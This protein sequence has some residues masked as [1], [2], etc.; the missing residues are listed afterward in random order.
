MSD[1]DFRF[2]DDDL[3]GDDDDLFGDDDD[4]FGGDDDFGSGF[5]DF[6][7]DADLDADLDIP[8]VGPDFTD[9][10]TVVVEEEGGSNRMFVIIA[11]IMLLLLI[12]GFA[13]IAFLALRGTV[14][15]E[16]DAT[17]TAIVAQNMTIEAF[18]TQTEIANTEIAAVTLTAAAASPTPT[19]TP[20]PTIDVPATETQ[21]AV[22][23]G[24]TQTFEA[25]QLTLT[26]SESVMDSLTE[27]AAAVSAE[28]AAATQTALA[29]GPSSVEQTATA[30]A[31]A[32]VP[33]MVEAPNLSEV[34]MTATALA[35]LFATPVVTPG[36]AIPTQE[37]IPT[38]TGGTPS[39]QLP[40]TGIFDDLAAG[41]PGT[42]LLAAF[43]LL[44]V[45]FVSR[46]VRKN[47]SA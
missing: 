24:I 16:R 9:V 7:N 37:I 29:V 34:Q 36:D 46:A 35:T 43:G 1:D 18:Q 25:D 31:L 27:T 15:P 44:G 17:A 14:N 26:Q 11:G 19:I 32:T 47:T 6:G 42:F 10:D 8:D 40:D 45:I 2:D 3:F 28:D 5:D 23:L 33:T 41:G 21:A 12:G 30:L 39:G 20:S 22:V 13:L 38:S 4:L